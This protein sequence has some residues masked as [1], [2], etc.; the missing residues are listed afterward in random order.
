M[1]ANHDQFAQESLK[2]EPRTASGDPANSGQ[3][4]PSQRPTNPCRQW[5]AEERAA[6]YWT[7]SAN[8]AVDEAATLAWLLIRWRVDP[9]M[10]AIEALRITLQP[11]QAQILLDLADAPQ[12]L[13]I[14][15]GLDPTKPK[16]QLIVPSG[17]G[18]GKTRVLAVAIWW[19]VLTHMFSKTL[20]TAPTSDQLTGQLWGELR[21]LYRRLKKRWPQLADEW[22]ILGSSI[23]HK[24][25]DNG[26]WFVT[27]R[28]ARPE[29][30]E[31][32]QGAHALDED[33]AFGQLSEIFGEDFEGEMS[34]GML[35]IIEEASGVADEVREV[36]E[37]A[38]SE[39]GARMLAVGNPTRPEGWFAEDMEKYDRYAV[40]YLDCRMSNREKVYQLPYRYYDGTVHHIQIRGFVQPKYWEDILT[41]CDG[42][43][44][45]DRVRVRVR[46]MKPRSAFEQCIRTNWLEEAE[47]RGAHEA[48][49][50]EVP[51][52]G[53]DFGL[54]FDKHAIAIRQG[55]NI[56]DVIEW[57]PKE[58]PEEIL[59]DAKDRIID[60]VELYKVR[61]IVGDSNGIGRMVMEELSKYYRERPELNVRVIHFNAGQGALDKKRF[62]RRR[63]EM[64]YKKGRAFFA[65]P[66]VSM[67]KVPGLKSQ[68]SAPGYHEDATRRV[69]VE[70]KDE[71]K[72][73]GIESGNGAD[74]VLQTLMFETPLEERKRNKRPEDEIPE[75]FKAHFKRYLNRNRP[76]HYIR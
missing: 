35:V 74:A 67:P 21:K 47:A 2:G 26:D 14:F 23:N 64:W 5:S 17:H 55:Y 32:L 53:S 36:L 50:A 58:K 30:T 27:A 76:S 33:D 57:L 54:S 65:S 8:Q 28:T 15:Y 44:D 72:K 29:K 68:L 41:D 4:P 19:H 38:L 18:L 40:H 12:D 24:D 20:C 62:Y 61:I 56:R 7:L 13:Y 37:G 43:E 60:A 25:P 10:F 1:S 63:D 39:E 45:A 6:W 66:F 49:S 22:N 71:L 34:G 59:M 52:L 9:I 16:R 73:R 11:Y 51:I 3:N 46:G 75:P 31:G 70:S 69:R 42:D 48:S